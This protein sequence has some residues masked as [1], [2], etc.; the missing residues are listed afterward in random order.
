MNIDPNLLIAAKIVHDECNKYKKCDMCPLHFI[1]D[2][3][4][5]Q[6]WEIHAPPPEPTERPRIEW[7]RALPDDDLID[8]QSRSVCDE[9]VYTHKECIESKKC[10]IGIH[11]WWHEVVSLEQFRKDVGVK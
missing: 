6:N 1:C 10:A 8:A 2:N 7:L 5:P 11:R 3:N 4:V 9:C